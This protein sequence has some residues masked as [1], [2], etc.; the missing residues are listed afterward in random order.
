MMFGRQIYTKSYIYS[1][2]LTIGFFYYCEYRDALENE[3][4]RYDRI[5]KERRITSACVYYL[6]TV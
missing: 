4:N 1:I 3:K 5:I 6:Q 2:L